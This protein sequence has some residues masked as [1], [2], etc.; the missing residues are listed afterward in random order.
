V[1]RP[2]PREQAPAGP[3]RRLAAALAV[4]GLLAGG[5]ACGSGSGR[6]AGAAAAGLFQALGA[7]I[8]PGQTVALNQEIRI[9]FSHAVDPASVSFSSVQF[10]PVS[11]EAQGQPVTGEFLLEE[12]S[13]DRILVFRPT[14]PTTEDAD[15][16]GFLPGG[17][18]YRLNLPTATSGG[19][20]VLRDRAGRLLS[21]G[22]SLPF[23]TPDPPA[24]PLFLDPV[25]GP[26]RLLA[27]DWPS[28]LNLFSDPDPV[29]RLDFD[30][31]LG[32]TAENLSPERFQI[33]YAAAPLGEDGDDAFDLS[34]QVPLA[35]V[36][37]ENCG[38]GGAR[39]ELWIAGL[40]PPQ[41]RLRLRVASGLEDLIGE[42][43]VSDQQGP[44]DLETP[45]LAELW[46]GTGWTE[47]QVAVDQIADQ[48]GVGTWVDFSEPLP[49]PPAEL[50]EDWLGAAFDWPGGFIAEDADF[51]WAGGLLEIS[52]EGL[53]AVTDSD[54]RTTVLQDG[55]WRVQDFVIEAGST[56]RV[57]SGAN[58]LI[59]YAAGEVRIDGSL[60]ASGA[61][62]EW[63][64]SIATPCFPEAGGIGVAGGGNGGVASWNATGPTLRGGSGQGPFGTGAGGGQGGEGGFQVFT[65][66]VGSVGLLRRISGGGGGGGF[67]RTPNVAIRWSE[68]TPEEIPGLFDETLCP[69][70]QEDRHTALGWNPLD[71][72]D[73]H[74]WWPRGAEDGLRGSSF[75]ND[76]EPG[77]DPHG[78]Y[79]MED[80]T[81]DYAVPAGHDSLDNL[82]PP[83][84]EG[85]E[86][87][88][89][90]G[91][92][93]AGPDPG[94]AG[95][96]VFPDDGDPLD[97]FWGVRVDA[98]GIARQGELLTPWAGSGGGAGGDSFD[99]PGVAGSLATQF[100]PATF[101]CVNFDYYK[102]GGG[103]GGGG[104]LL[105]FAVGPIRLGP[106]ARI[107][108]RGGAGVGGQG[109]TGFNRQIS[110]SGGGSGGH[111]VLHSASAL[112]LSG[113]D[114][115]PGQTLDSAQDVFLLL[116]ADGFTRDWL[117]QARGGRR[118]HCAS[119]LDPDES[120]GALFDGNSTFQ[121]G[122]GGAGAN[123]V[124]QIHV[125]DPATDLLWH[126][127]LAAG[128]ADFLRNGQEE[129]A[130]DPDRAEQLLG[131]VAA[132]QPYLLVP[133]FSSRSVARSAW[134]DTGLAFLRRSEGAAAPSTPDWQPEGTAFAGTETAGEEAGRVLTD[135]E[136][137][138][139]SGLILAG[140][141]EAVELEEFQLALVPATAWLP[142][143][144][145]RA[146]WL[147]VPDL[148]LGVE[149]RN[150]GTGASTAVTAARFLAAED[151]LELSLDPLGPPSSAL[152]PAGSSWELRA[153][154]FEVETEGQRHVLPDRSALWIEFQGAEDPDDPAT[155]LP[156][157]GQ[158]T[159]DLS[160][161][162][163]RRF[164]RFQVTF[165]LD[166]DGSGDLLSAPRPRLRLLKIPFGW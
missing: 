8:G 134:I 37:Q 51:R 146:A 89:E 149:L 148:W 82:D 68:W 159:A 140:T 86:P 91:D 107:V 20:A 144:A 126:P 9:E 135:A 145:G 10:Q 130:V 113:V 22:L 69:D 90:F 114:L 52:T 133:F 138:P 3:L 123:G 120:C 21:R 11:P 59:L 24:E 18:E 28:G 110:G 2:A 53:Q 7:S 84:T 116:Q 44:E 17:L 83:W 30:Q 118:G 60:E 105:V 125:P 29:V 157:P 100:P 39:V 13:G 131:L 45:S 161:L 49:L 58:P 111:I 32:L 87:P 155:I 75:E 79:G 50:G 1:P 48:F 64:S 95:E 112:D 162:R 104:Q 54:N 137:V 33:L 88:F 99:I 80:E 163:G 160:T 101:P 23:R 97:D 66:D 76:L 57:G 15:D 132:P 85:E 62:A 12:G 94:F 143:A 152:L 147:R 127:S 139:D 141:A 119:S 41:R 122:R 92:P 31:P 96:S 16:G 108:A 34:R 78:T 6:G 63:P 156:G 71:F 47:E 154:W 109:A 102:G 55:V 165:D 164:L 128:F 35:V 153:R 81:I 106:G 4:L 124:I 42:A 19:G 72:Y 25:A 98:Q 129:G 43:T 117:V 121:L 70:H 26:P 73:Q 14:C 77:F 158:W 93:V 27:V 151:R 74:P 166:A 61:D 40:L 115:A 136:S 56:V 65:S 5:A 67:A 46:S 103:G 38:E 36:L 150:P 142:A